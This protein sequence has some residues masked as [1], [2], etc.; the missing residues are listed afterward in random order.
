MYSITLMTQNRFN[1]KLVAYVVKISRGRWP[2]HPSGKT[3]DE[4]VFIAYLCLS[5]NQYICC[6]NMLY[7]KL[8]K[9]TNKLLNL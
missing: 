3:P 4:C 7:D 1:V 5:C 6:T 8:F 2:E 9:P